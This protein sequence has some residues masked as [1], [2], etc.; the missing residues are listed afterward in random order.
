M[1]ITEAVS[2][3]E[4]SNAQAPNTK[5]GARLRGQRTTEMTPGPKPAEVV[6]L[7][8]SQV[9]PGGPP[10]RVDPTMVDAAT[11]A[12]MRPSPDPRHV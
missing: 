4:A 9:E 5:P 11:A 8:G 12:R 2:A 6:E 1:S 7:S 10:V 3:T